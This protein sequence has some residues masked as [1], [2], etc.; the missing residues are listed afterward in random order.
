MHTCA[1][2]CTHTCA[3][4]LIT[5]SFSYSYFFFCIA[6]MHSCSYY[7]ALTNSFLFFFSYFF[8]MALMHS[9][10]YYMALT[11]SF[12]YS[13]L[14]SYG[15]D[16]F[17]FLLHGFDVSIFLSHGFDVFIFLLFPRV[18]LYICSASRGKHGRVGHGPR[19]RGAA[20]A[21]IAVIYSYG[22]CS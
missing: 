7:M 4:G 12:S 20:R 15:F 18:Y 19:P 14:H 8:C 21:H 5:Y 2:M 3:Q 9:C 17:I 1:Y 13:Y 22:Y 11:N 16:V 6:L 10:S